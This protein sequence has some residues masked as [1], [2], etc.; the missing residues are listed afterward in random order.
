MIQSN[1]GLDLLKFGDQERPLW[2]GT[3]TI[4]DEESVPSAKAQGGKGLGL[5]EKYNMIH[6]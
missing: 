4:T 5:F 6:V 2:E 1:E 3:F